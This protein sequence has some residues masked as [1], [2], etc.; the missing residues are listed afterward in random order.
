[1]FQRFLLIIIII[2]TF[3]SEKNLCAQNSNFSDLYTNFSKQY[4]SGDF[5]NAELSLLSVL[6]SKESI[7]DEILMATYNNLGVINNRL[8]KYEEALIYYN[9][10]E[11]DIINNQQGTFE[12][13][14]I[15]VNKARIYGI[16]KEFDKAIEYLEQGVKIYLRFINTNTS[17]YHRISSVYL[18]LGL[19]YYEKKDYKNALVYLKK[20]EEIKLKNKLSEIAF[21]YLNIAKV[22]VKTINNSKAEEYFKKSILAFN[23][24]FGND[25]YRT[26]SVLFDYGL[27]LRSIGKNKEALDIHQ[28][29]LSIC[30]KNY[31]NKHTFVSLAYKHLGDNYFNQADYKTALEYYQ[32]SLIAVVNDFN[33]TEIYSNPSLGSVI[34][35]IRLLDNLKRKSQALELYSLQQVSQENRQLILVKSYETI[36]L[37]LQLISRI[38]SGY[39]SNDSR[40][41]LVENEK[42]T[43]IFATHIAQKLY[44]ITKEQ[45]YL[46]RMYYITNLSKS[47]ILRNEI[48]ENELFFRKVI[49]DSLHDAHNNYIGNIASY[50]KLIQ[51]EFQKTKPDTQKINL[52]KDILFDLKRNIEQVDEQ[53]KGLFPQYELLLKRTDPI[54]L[55]EIQNYLKKDETLIEYFLSNNYHEGK[56]DLFIFTVKHN[57][58]DY[59]LT[60]ID[61]LFAFSV[62]AIK[63]ST[64]NIMNTNDN[65]ESYKS[66][67]NALYY[68]YEKLI[69]P[70]ETDLIGNKLIIVPDEEIAY[71]PFEAFISKKSEPTQI[72]YEGLQYLIYD[73]TISY[74]YSTSLI[75]IDEK[76]K[77]KTDKL[78]AFSPN[79]DRFQKDSGNILKKLN[80]TSKEIASISRWFKSYVY[81]GGMATESNFKL[82]IKKPAIF[83]LAMHSQTDSSNSKYSYLIFE[84]KP[85]SHDDGK[86][87]NY[88]ISLNRI[89]SPMVVLSACNTGTG[90]L[91]HGEGVMSLA[92]GF[93]LAGASSVINTFWDVNDDASSMIM[94]D[95]YNNLSK[96]KEKDVAL[97]LA[98]LKYLKNSPPTFANPYYW[99]AYEVMGDKSPIKSRRTVYLILFIGI[100]TL[101][102]IFSS[103]Y[104]KRFRRS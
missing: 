79:Y 100:M 58:I 67:T 39:I 90:N 83:H 81:S 60:F 35:D 99:A 56:R 24:E 23:E 38:R 42:E 46:Q 34:F 28:K 102:G 92:R 75:Y 64:V 103:F 47:A 95:F 32:K 30:L 26:S 94:I 44:E 88:E 33:D 89:Q 21:T 98:K 49:P 73:Y 80:G 65:L 71:L 91:Y 27:F 7:P 59:R 61:S 16:L 50:N 77:L 82:S 4:A 13:A 2:S 66:Y 69:K 22:Y 55:K 19:T 86:L 104:F 62:E 15:Y 31:G 54:T 68:M 63:S 18:N 78:I 17:A 1:M 14:D 84:S 25:Y 76:D 5:I 6:K 12:L 74:G 37:A 72:N 93:I 101:S 9:L 70:V 3:T 11:K 57:K 40:I 10:A 87:Y 52:W 45:E 20:S 85:D 8:G 29:A 96:G 53:I 48:A 43:Y 97:R 51:D 41:Y 36:E